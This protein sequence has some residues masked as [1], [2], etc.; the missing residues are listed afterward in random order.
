[1]SKPVTPLLE[2]LR[3]AT[4]DQRERMAALA[5]TTVNYIYQV[6]TLER[7]QRLS[8][9]MAF[10]LEDAMTTVADE[11]SAPAIVTA[12]ELAT[13]ANLAGLDT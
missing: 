3:A 13:M 4:P 12:R 5:G 10:R 7:G 2:W 9:D 1:M 6:A 8:A 11:G